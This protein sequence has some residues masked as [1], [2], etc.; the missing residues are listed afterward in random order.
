MSPAVYFDF[1]Q[2]IKAYYSKKFDK[3]R[4]DFVTI[5]GEPWLHLSLNDALRETY[6]IIEKNLGLY[7]YSD[8]YEDIIKGKKVERFEHGND[9]IKNVWPGSDY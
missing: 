1:E 4:Y 2:I 7:L 5:Y 8:E 3:S 6:Y 9:T